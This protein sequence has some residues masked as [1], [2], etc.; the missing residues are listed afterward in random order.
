MENNIDYKDPKH[1]LNRQINYTITR[2]LWK[3]IKSSVESENPKDDLYKVFPFTRNAY[4]LLVPG[5]TYQTPKINKTR[6]RKLEETGIS[7]EVFTGE[8]VLTLTNIT[9]D[10]WDTYFKCRYPDPELKDKNTAST[11]KYKP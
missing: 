9:R 3:Y 1:V 7:V 11:Q 10:E 2:R 4:T 8:V 5:N 6:R